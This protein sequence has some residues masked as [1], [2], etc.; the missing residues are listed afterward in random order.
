MDEKLREAADQPRDL[1]ERAKDE[2]SAWFGNPEAASRR[3]QDLAVGDHSGQGPA[4]Y[5]ADPDAR[6][7]DEISERLTADAGLDASHIQVASA[8]GV[9]T[10]T[11]QV[12]TSAQR[13]QAEELA[14][15]AAGVS[16]VDNRLEIV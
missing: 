4:D 3:Q 5:H 8:S 2:V 9:V 12:T 14:R 16:H 1:L 11:G 13:H 6:I 15:S 7:V 10:L